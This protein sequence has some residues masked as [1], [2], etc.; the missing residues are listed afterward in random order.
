[1]PVLTSTERW[2]RTRLRVQ[3]GSG[4]S[5][6]VVRSVVSASD[7]AAPSLRP[8]LMDRRRDHAR[9]CL[10]PEGALLLAGDGVEMDIEVG[11]GARLDLV[12]PGG[13]V[14]F[15]MR[16]AAARWSVRITL[17]RDA[18]LTWAGEPFVVAAGADVQRDTVIRLGA[19]ARL[20]L[21]ETLVLGRFGEVPGR[22]RLTTTVLDDEGPL[23]VEDLPL[24]ASSAAGLLGGHRVMASVLCLGP[25][26]VSVADDQDPDRYDLH[27]GGTLWRRLGAEVH[28]SG[29]GPAWLT[30]LTRV[31]GL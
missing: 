10:V 23:L 24:D 1:M 17:G 27:A 2:S 13:T 4:G 21:R 25:D 29:L 28:T 14:A 15:D 31:V 8:M 6:T 16:G 7:T 5:P 20:A 19:G 26:P 3:R 11:D 9:V 30:S 18:C 22:V 12:E